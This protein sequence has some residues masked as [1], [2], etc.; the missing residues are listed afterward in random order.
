DADLIWGFA[1]FGLV[2]LLAAIR[3]PLAL[4]L[5]GVG[6]LGLGLVD[7]NLRGVYFAL[8][9]E[10]FANFVRWEYSIIP[11][12]LLMGEFALRGGLGR[13]LFDAAAAR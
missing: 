11:L 4:C 3:I 8:Q 13:G 5:F 7:G 1:G 6:L 9:A 10:T 12:F 2:L